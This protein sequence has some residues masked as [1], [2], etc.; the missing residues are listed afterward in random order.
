MTGKLYSLFCL[1]L[2]IFLSSSSVVSA[3]KFIHPGVDMTSSDL[4]YMKKQVLAGEQ[5]WKDAFERLKISTDLQFQVKPFTHVVRG[6]YGKPNIGGD[7]LSKGSNLAYD[8]TLMWYITGEKTYAQKAI[9]ILNAWSPV[10]WD[11]DYNDAKLLA[12]WTGHLLCNAAEILRY[13]DS[14]WQ[15]KDIDRFTEMLMTVYYPLM[16]FYYPQANGNW[17]GAIIHSILA[18]AIFTDNSEM[19]DN[20]VH[21]FLHAPVNGSIFKYI[22]PSGQCQESMRDQGHVQL[23]LGEFAGAARVAFT[24]GIDLFSFGNNRIALGYEYTA[25]FLLGNPPQCYGKISERSKKFRDDYEYVYRQYTSMGMDMPNTK[26]AADSIRPKASRSVLTAFRAPSSKPVTN[27]GKPKVSPIAYPAGAMKLAVTKPAE[28]AIRVNPGESLQEALDK[29]AVNNGWVIAAAGLHTIPTTL[30]IPSGVTL[31]GEGLA[32][33]IFL[34]PKSGV[35]D[36][37]VNQSDD[38]HHVTICDL[39]V[40][41]AA[42][43]DPGTDPNSRRSYRGGSNRGG[44]IFLGQHEAQLKNIVLRNVT[45]R[46]CTYNGVFISGAENLQIICCDLNENGSS[47]VPGPKLQHNLLL[48]HCSGITI[49]DSRM[50][51]S[52]FGSGIALNYCNQAEIKNCEIARN[53]FYGLLISECNQI[54]ASGCLVE[55]NDRSGIMTEYLNTG[56]SD[57]LL[58][59]N[60]V[61]Y[62]NG[63]GIESYAAKNLK[64]V[65]NSFDGNGLNL[66]SNEKISPEKCIVMQ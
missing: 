31:S 7:D 64:S 11:F 16:R 44:I 56:S 34:D 15:K 35:R 45:V 55:A 18:I 20:A 49:S 60:Q 32:T 28:N 19:F 52:P 37:M 1:F 29:A 3:R 12:G 36:A 26:Q 8:C 54:K 53:A 66:K 38:M 51:T 42:D 59:D 62:N 17:D 65:N 24:Q 39:V 40:E 9:E 25:Q 57:I 4:E 30:K 21:H 61:Q 23:G 22:Y 46:N 63:Y 50:D 47:V 2:I 43:P 6:P 14:G 33:I 27:Q 41:G 58:K 5:P 10:L 13:T 48:T